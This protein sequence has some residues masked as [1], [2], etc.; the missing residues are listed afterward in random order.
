M[1]NKK[2]TIILLIST[3]FAGAGVPITKDLA[4][5]V[6]PIFILA[7]RFLMAFIMLFALKWKYIVKH[8]KR[9]DIKPIFIVACFC[10]GG[11]IFYNLAVVYTTATNAA[12]FYSMSV[13]I[14]PF[15]AKRVNGT[16]YNKGLL[17]GIAITVIGMV[18]LIFNTGEISIN[19]GD[20]LGLACAVVFAFHVVYTG[21]Y[22]DQVDP[23]VLADVQFVF[24]GT[25]SLAISLIFEE[26]SLANFAQGSGAVSI[27]YLAFFGTVV[28]YVSQN[29]AQTKVT[30][31]MI[32]IIFAL[33]PL[34]GALSSW[35]I[36]G[37]TLSFIGKVGCVLMV[38]GV[39]VANKLN[40]CDEKA[41]AGAEEIS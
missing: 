29:T 2:L 15:V 33:I 41:L 20:L 22:V 4:D 27:F 28:I 39:L 21:K 24:V 25:M 40:S 36:L 3:I 35:V 6:P 32:G 18:G 5:A 8:F 37:E 30:E 38:L 19:L 14:I 16:P 17:I 7:V 11:Y 10:T 34:Y 23:I 31:S 9:A 1:S 13:L 12:F 26:G